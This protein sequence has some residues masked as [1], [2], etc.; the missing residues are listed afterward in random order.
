M[1][2][3]TT[4]E[5]MKQ[6]RLLGMATTY[7]QSLSEHLY[8]DHTKDQF[9]ALLVDQ[10][11]EDRQNRKIKNLIRQANFRLSAS[12]HDVD[13]TS[14]RKLDKNQFERLLGLQ[15][16]SSAE[17]VIFTGPTGVGKSYLAQ[18]IGTTACQML[19]RVQY[20]NTARLMEHV[21]ITKLDGTYIK[22][23]KRLQKVPLLILDDFGLVSLDQHARQALMDILEDRYGKAS[24]V[25]VSQIPIAQW[26]DVI[27][28]GTIAD[29]ILDRLVYAAHQVALEGDSMR[30]KKKLKG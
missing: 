22:L 21:K 24:T 18:A 12:A 30:K 11:W 8:Q 2:Q 25:V 29:A 6:M 19:Y 16:L 20:Y 23:L 1:N 27:G 3:Q 4:I 10:E 17:N 5:R 15:F 26:H 13:Y 7:H 9:T 28:E 14:S